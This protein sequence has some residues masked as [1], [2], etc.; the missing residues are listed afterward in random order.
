MKI[1][2]VRNA[3]LLVEFGGLT[4]LI[5]PYLARKEAYPG[6]EGTLNSHLRNPRVELKTPM[7]AILDVDAV[8]VT[9]THEDHWD[10]AA[11]TLLP[12]QLRVYTQ[13]EKDAELIRSQGFSEVKVL[14][15][16]E[17]FGSVTLIKTPGQHGSDEVV[18][19]L[20][21]RAG[22]V[23]GIVLTHPREQTLYV[24][25]DTVWNDQV[26]SSLERYEPGVVV[27]NAGDAQVPGLGPIIMGAEDVQRVCEVAPQAT[28]V[29]S[30]LEAVNHAALTRDELRDFT[31]QAGIANRVLVPEDDEVCVFPGPESL[32][33]SHKKTVAEF[34]GA[35][36]AGDFEGIAAYCH[37]DFVFFP[38]IDTPFRGVDGFVASEKHKFEAFDEWQMRIEQLVAEGDKVAAYLVFEGI[39][40][41]E[42]GGIA[43]SGNKVRI[44][45]LMLLTMR[46][47]LIIEKRAHF[48]P[49]DVAR[50]MVAADRK[51]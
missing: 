48:D 5:D 10:A 43:P 40:A 4:F 11:A 32:G 35:I 34:Y 22:D 12:K 30:H 13:H 25:G 8:I 3:T 28:V 9:H 47:G 18:A 17:L 23:C 24:A 44:S 38:Q 7:G 45:L 20:G 2:Q 31:Q 41:R 1:R 29:A 19:A 26:K 42:F 14:G 39:H 49:R 33:N 15:S 51:R 27:L 6:F 36:D 50:Q 46:D 37:D 21:D 16:G